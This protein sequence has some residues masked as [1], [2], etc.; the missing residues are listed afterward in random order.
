MMDRAAVARAL[1]TERT[2]D[3]TTIGRKSG[4]LRRIEMWFHNVGGRIFLTGSPGTRDW[5]ANL[6]VDPRFTFHLKQS[7]TADLAATARIITNGEEKR[8]VLE[9]ITARVGA[10]NLSDWLERSP[11]IE[12]VFDEESL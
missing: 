7:V 5:F 8:Q 4:R 1:R 11:L 2:I 10:G 12:V 6:V 9:V 3:I